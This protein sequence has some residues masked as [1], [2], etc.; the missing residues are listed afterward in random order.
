MS[1]RDLHL[2]DQRAQQL[3]DGLLPGPAAAEAGQ[4]LAGCQDCRLLVDSYR[5]LAEALDGL[6]PAAPP[7]DF[8]EGVL[9][10][11]DERER[12]AARERRAALAV[13]AGAAGIAAVLLAAAGGASAWAPVLSRAGD[14]LGA[15]ATGIS[16]A[17]DVLTPVVGALR[18]QIAAASAAAA[19][20]LLV[21]LHR[22]SF[23]RAE[24]TA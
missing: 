3:L 6:E 10:R 4:H 21:A 24:A 9:A 1:A 11:I 5:A 8:T 17:A 18:L 12:N 2:D 16:V 14:L 23:R 13:L 7:A 22:L 20:P 15:A 19:V